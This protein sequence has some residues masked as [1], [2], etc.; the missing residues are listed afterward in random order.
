MTWHGWSIQPPLLYVAV[1]AMLYWFG[2]LGYRRSGRDGWHAVAFAAGLVT[3]VLALESPIDG[4]ADQLFWVHMVQHILLLTVAPPLILLGRPWPRMWRALPLPTRTRVGRTL[5]RA[6]WTAPVRAM[7]RPLPAFLLFNAT[8]IAW[9]VPGAYNATLRSWVVHDLE[10]AMFFF[11][12]LLFWAR[13]IDPGPLRPRL[14]WPAR[15]AFTVGAM[16]VGWVLAITL[17]LVPHPLYSFY[18]ELAHRPGGISALTDQQLAAGMMWVPGSIAY[19]ITFMIGFYRWL[20]PD[21]TP[22]PAERALRTTLS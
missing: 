2:G 17:V 14:V 21:A 15:I 22:A 9:H 7:A 5:A 8:V 16:V 13:V 1:A 3:I 6:R 12:G 4:Y 11:T 18:A 19:T 10:H 20:E